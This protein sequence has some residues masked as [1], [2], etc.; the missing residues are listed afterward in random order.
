LLGERR[1]KSGKGP[2]KAETYRAAR[3]NAV[4]RGEVAQLWQGVEGIYS[5]IHHLRS[6]RYPYDGV[7]QRARYARQHAKQLAKRAVLMQEAAE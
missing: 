4:L 2:R 1:K 3:R 5:P 7:R 6:R